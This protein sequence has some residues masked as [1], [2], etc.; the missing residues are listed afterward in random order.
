MLNHHDH[1]ML[2][3]LLC[4][5]NSNGSH[6]QGPTKPSVSKP[7]KPWGQQKGRMLVGRL[8]LQGPARAQAHSI[9]YKP[10]TVTHCSPKN[11]WKIKYGMD[12][13]DKERPSTRLPHGKMTSPLFSALTNGNVR[14]LLHELAHFPCIFVGTAVVQLEMTC[15]QKIVK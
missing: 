12:Y 2:N 8:S 9:Q 4:S 3:L 7:S 10:P 11:R 6:G 13:S 1:G 5:L 14:F 15:V